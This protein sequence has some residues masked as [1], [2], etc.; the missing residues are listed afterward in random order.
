MIARRW[1]IAQPDTGT[2]SELSKALSIPTLLAA[3][4]VNRGCTSPDPAQQYLDPKLARLSDPFLLP[5]MHRA[6]DRLFRAHQEKECFVIFG[7]YDVDGVTATAL[8]TEVFRELGWECVY[9]LPHRLEEGYG[10]SRDGITN[11]LA[12][13]DVKLVIAVDCGSKDREVIGELAERGIEVIVLDHHQVS[14]P[15]PPAI[16]LVNPQLLEGLHELKNLCSAGLA[17]KLA[18]ALLK[19]ARQLGWD[20]A[21]QLDI[22]QYLDLVA[23]GTI[24]DIVPLKGENRTFTRKGL[25]QLGSTE[26]PG[27]KALQKVAGITGEVCSH[28]VSFQ[29][30]PRLNAAGRLDTAMDSLELLLTH[31]SERAEAL[32]SALDQQ[33][34]ERQSLEQ[35]IAEEVIEAVRARFNPATDYAI[36]EG[37]AGWHIGVVG[38][39]ASR[40]LR[41]FH[42][43]VLILGSD[44]SEHWRGSGRSIEGFDLAAGLR[45]CGDILL[46]HGG[47]AM[48]AGLTIAAARLGDLRTRLNDLVRST[49]TND[50]LSPLLRL[51]AEV[52]LSELTFQSLKSFEKMEPTGQ[53]NPPIQLAA[54]RLTARGEL[55][56]FG[57]DQQ[58][59]RFFVSQNGTS[60]QALWWNAPEAPLP[61]VFDLAFAP[62][63]SEY[64]GTFAVQLRVLDL[65][66]AAT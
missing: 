43:P 61:E 42:R 20:R 63:L 31:D 24:A 40:V 56:R 55:K 28:E 46:K 7:D 23:L 2:V 4:L 25:E 59:L 3:C 22:R 41:E 44:G 36:V 49:I 57:A 35:R 13:H 39:V 19:R 52:M 65:R 12:Q 33:N 34:R 30:A 32:A 26:R 18:H 51:D 10:L 27:L 8:L 58:H 54:R 48:A 5:D 66:P 53:G 47:H 9:Y 15:P 11:C 17:F 29:L 50:A 1:Q 21:N 16:A 14:S 45:S 37:N 6:V 60:H 62:E 64:N 38:I